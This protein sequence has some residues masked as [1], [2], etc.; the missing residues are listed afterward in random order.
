MVRPLIDAFAARG[1][2]PELLRP[3]VGVRPAYLEAALDEVDRRFG[4]ID[5]YVAEGLGLDG[6]TR[7]AL[8]ALLVERA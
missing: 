1:G 6:P 7:A 4:S 8:R 5:G 2:D 3:L